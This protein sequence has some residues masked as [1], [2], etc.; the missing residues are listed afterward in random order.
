MCI[1]KTIII[2]LLTISFNLLHPA[3]A[4]QVNFSGTLMNNPPCTINGAEDPI[5]INFERVGISQIY[6]DNV[7]Q[8]FSIKIEC[9]DRLGQDVPLYIGYDGMKTDFDPRALQTTK[10]GLGVLLKRDNGEVIA[11]D[12]ADHPITLTGGIAKD[13]QFKAVLVKDT[14]PSSVLFEGDFEANARIE[15]RYP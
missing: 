2:S 5:I 12:N 13:L 15:I 1:R 14:N 10:S 9:E 11:A 4:V 6:G 3:H 7:A 8:T